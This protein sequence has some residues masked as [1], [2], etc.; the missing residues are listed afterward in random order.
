MNKGRIDFLTKRWPFIRG[1]I[2]CFPVS[3]PRALCFPAAL[4]CVFSVVVSLWAIPGIASPSNAVPSVPTVIST[5]CGGSV[6]TWIPFGPKTYTRPA[7]PRE[8]EDSRDDDEQP[9]VTDSFSVQNVA[10]QYTLHIDTN[11]ASGAV[12]RINGVTI[13]RPRDFHRE[14]E[15]A[16]DKGEDSDLL[17]VIEK[18]VHLLLNNKIEV[19]VRGK[20]GTK[21][22]LSILG[23][24]NDPPAISAVS[25]PAANSA[26]WDN[27][28]VIV[29]FTC[30]DATS[31]IAVCP[32]PATVS[33]EGKAQSV[34]G[35][36]VDKAG[37]TTTVAIYVS[38]DKTPP[39]ITAT[40]IPPPVNG[41]VILPV[42]GAVTINFACTDA[43]SGI[44]SCPAA[45]SVTTV[46]PNQV[47]S[48]TA[49][50]NAGNSA[51]AN[52]A[53]NVQ[54]ASP[55][56][57][58][59]SVSSAI[60]ATNG[61]Y[62]NDVTITYQCSGGVPPLQ[63]PPSQMISSEGFD[64][65]ITAT[66]NDAAGQTASTTT[67]LN[68]DKTP[69]TVIA[70]VTPAPVNGIVT[71]PAGGVVTIRFTC[72]DALSGI[73]T[74]PAD[75]SVN[76]P[77]ANQLFNGSAIDQA[78]NS[79]APASVT[80]SVQAAQLGITA[81]VTPSPN[82]A[83]WDNADT[84]VSFQDSGGVPPLQVSPAQVVNTEG[85]N[86]SIRGSVSDAAGQVVTTTVLVNL[87]KTPPTITGAVSPTPNAAG[88][89]NTDPTVIFT[90][91]DATSGISSCPQPQ[92]V[93]SEGARQTVSG[94]A[95][96]VAGN[97]ANSS[98]TINVDKTPP[99]ITATVS[100]A[101]NAA[102]WNNT[103]PTVTFTCADARS[104]ISNCPQSQVVTSEGAQ[105]TIS[106]TATDVAG[107]AANSSVTL[108]VDKT[109]PSLTITSPINGSTIGLSTSS[110]SLT[111]TAN[112]SL[113]GI[114]IITCNRAAASMSSQGFVC[115]VSLTQGANSILV[116]A[117]DVAGNSTSSTLNLTYAPAPQVTITSPTNL[118][119]TN[120]T[121]VT[122]NGTVNDPAATL[123]VNGIPAPQSSGSFS[124]P[125]PLVE[126]LNVLTVVA[127][128]TS[129]I[130]STA[131]IQ[132]TLDTT[133]PHITIDSPSDGTVTTDATATVTGLANDVVVGTVN[134]QDV[135]VTV[136][137]VAAQVANR[138]YAAANVPLTLGK[139]T[140][141]AVAHD[142]AGN[143][144]TTS[145]MVTRVLSTQPPPPANGTAVITQSLGVVSGNNQTGTIGTQLPA[146]LV[147]ALT[148][149]TNHPVANQT[150]VFKV[151]GN[152]GVLNAGGSA[153]PSAAITV[154]TDLNGQA[155]V[156][157]T[158][159]QRSG[160]GINAVQASSALAVGSANFTATGVTGSAATIVVDSGS[161]QTGVVGQALPFPFVAAVVDSGHNRVPNVPVTFT[162]KSGG[163]NLNGGSSQTVQTDS[164]GR[165]IAVLTLG[166]QT[167]NANSVVEATFPGNPG[168]AAA[169]AA[170]ARI[171]A[172]P[173]NTGISGVVLD[174]SNNPIQGVT[175]RLFQT[176]QGNNNNLPVQVSPSVQTDA[177][178]AFLIQPAP[179]G[180]FKLMADGTTATGPGS[181]PTLEYDIV[182]VAGND[183]T[184]GMP[185]YLPALDTV[186]KLCV[187]E[188]H[189]GT[190]TL[191]QVP[192]FGL[193]IL[194]GSATF[195][196]GS[197]Q[198]CITVTPVNGDKVPMSPGFGQQ[199]RFIVSI[200]PAGTKFDPPA[201][202]TLPN[203]D[204]LQSRSVTEMY[205]YDHD[206][207]M[208]IAIG[209][210]TVSA[211]G[212]VITSNAGVGVLKAGWHCGGNPNPTGS[213]GTCPECQ[214]CQGSS[215]VADFSQN[216]A[217]CSN[218]TG[219]CCGGS[220]LTATVSIDIN[221]TPTNTDDMALLNPPHPI[222]VQ[223]SL[224]TPGRCPVN[225]VLSATPVGRVTFD[226]TSINLLNG[227][228]GTVMITPN[229]VSQSPN[230]VKIIAKVNG[231]VVGTA[232]MTVVDVSIP[233]I[234]NT[235]TPAGVPDRIPPYV[236]TPI[237]VT[238]NPNLGASGQVVTLANLNT[239]GFPNGDFT[240]DGNKSEDLTASTTVNLQGTLQTTP[241]PPPGGGNAG[242]L[243]L[244]I[245]LGGQNAGQSSGFS[246]AAI[247]ISMTTSNPQKAVNV[248]LNGQG[249]L[250]GMTV[251]FVFNSDS[252]PSIYNNNNSNNDLTICEWVEQVQIVSSSGSLKIGV[253]P[254]LMLQNCIGSTTD[255]HFTPSQLLGPGASP[256][257]STTNQVYIFSS[258]R[259]GVTNIPV[260]NSGYQII[261]NLDQASDGTWHITVSKVGAMVTANGFTSAAG[262]TSGTLMKTVP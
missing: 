35:T 89:N 216:S 96:D 61:W 13:V 210:G 85:A 95:T 120:L 243:N 242:K 158:L 107:N 166:T 262:L 62:R 14:D 176:N 145:V 11:T 251:D 131:T 16:H 112:D 228:P 106:G 212:S 118:S 110:I 75:I 184:V 47:F 247:P 191:P 104:G 28:D 2:T 150:V 99:T 4:I 81:S 83:G 200:Q 221:N 151:T 66:V 84:T 109:P 128:N 190:L 181:Y 157:W 67:H 202:M 93:T 250:T 206:L 231:R 170:S 233:K 223:L 126:G 177:K 8:A 235:D 53:L 167:G 168:F 222:P 64:Q 52:V 244:A 60:T 160:T 79:S 117:T 129:G 94:A 1:K 214:K 147:V 74:C 213:A 253:E 43:L 164:N 203:V 230:D 192:G 224:H 87:D 46:G 22:I 98:V 55:P 124:I 171:P 196:G 48:G 20:P 116:Q 115:A 49:T 237:T 68:I 162:V 254:G 226:Q 136:N 56:A 88:W 154:N 51:S 229:A 123:T 260:P 193:T 103:D 179:V 26:G 248:M 258:L 245:L 5:N 114:S 153:T 77:G 111:G 63:C 138:T 142:R 37:N 199:P 69:P 211:D 7:R 238:V 205:S 148:D 257:A 50:D 197:R 76:T 143:G 175:L 144:T 220:C 57:I 122:V 73:A 241:T 256:G 78:G 19:K 10:A 130:V 27:S 86:Q 72:S 189:G 100:P 252:G 187:D 92:L 240:I 209:T 105:Q 40:V 59:A 185:I 113:S 140:I 134:A 246:I 21:L 127:T 6:C 97:T 137:G 178:G 42:G 225:V 173:A 36:A 125:V 156:L 3:S 219:Y 31:G 119:V 165:A 15:G 146:P 135:Q 12:V 41:T 215:C 23:V 182:T 194:P 29:M 139:N 163:G 108:N 155:Q 239:S 90:C 161:D 227:S 82:G 236:N 70:T 71:I 232:N 54:A 208:F 91:N 133:P 234:R 44:A 159:G 9:F 261:R 174:N 169:F 33:S 217:P 18:P 17:P 141:Q 183:N 188:T 132:A 259:L 39:T 201:P 38:I 249:P 255:H 152:D 65:Q 101:P 80:L 102:G 34:Q 24:D 58:S 180:S 198:G 207:G 45:V 25:T 195:P 218:G 32:A 121:P 186:N 30:S 149:S 172:N 204:G